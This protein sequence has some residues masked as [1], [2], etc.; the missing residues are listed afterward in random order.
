MTE[1]KPGQPQVIDL[2]EA[3]RRSLAETRSSPARENAETADLTLEVE[4]LP[5]CAYV[6]RCNSSRCPKH[7]AW[8]EAVAGMTEARERF[9]PAAALARAESAEAK[10]AAVREVIAGTER[11]IDRRVSKDWRVAEAETAIGY[12][13]IRALLAPSQSQPHECDNDDCQRCHHVGALLAP[14]Q[15]EGGGGNG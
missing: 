7:G 11:R 1:Q 15:G 9:S 12:R 13:R 14:S 6:G 4:R 8:A 2:G 3:L 10:L 5:D